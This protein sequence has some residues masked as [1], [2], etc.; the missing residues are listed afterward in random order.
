MSDTTTTVAKTTPA[1][2][3][4]SRVFVQKLLLIFLGFFSGALVVEIALRLAGYS[5]PEFYQ[6]DEYRGYALRPRAQ[7]WYRKEGEAYVT[8]NSDGLRDREHTK[9]KPQNTFRVALVGDSYPEALPVSLESTFWLVMERKLQDCDAASG[10]TIEV[11]NFGVSGYGT[12]QELIT[13]RERVWQ[14]QP[15]LVLL[16]VTTSNDITDNSRALKGTDRVP[17]FVLRQ[18]QLVL[19]DSYRRSRSF[20]FQQ[21]RIAYI[22]RWFRNNLRVVQALGQAHSALRIRFTSWRQHLT[23]SP[24]TESQP[25]K[26]SDLLAR[27][28]ELGND[29]LVYSA[30]QNQ[31]WID[32][33]L[34]TES[35]LKQI[36]QEVGERGAKLV[37]VTLSNAPQVIPDP[38]VRKRFTERFM[39]DDLFYPD[40]RLKTLF[41]SESIPVVVLAP[42]LQTYAELNEVFLHGFGENLGSGHWNVAGHRVAG[43][44]LAQ[45]ICAAGL[46]K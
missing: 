31:V 45:K 13:I 41:E 33:W 19:D 23:T 35:L 24:K 40:H 20:R 39:V 34:V 29:N 21:S 3:S 2:T 37:V 17:Y 6:V 11:I 32:A 10:R 14:Y 44:L 27:S 46:L 7:G 25:E 18:S 36:N 1:S 5:F 28:A 16:A 42:E 43:E 12:A 4:R 26:K 15:D 30:P 22:G 8:I 9:G 38:N